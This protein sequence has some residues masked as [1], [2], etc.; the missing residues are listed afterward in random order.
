MSILTILL[1]FCFVLIN[2]L[3]PFYLLENIKRFFHFNTINSFMLLLCFIYFCFTCY[4]ILDIFSC[5]Y[6]QCLNIFA[7]LIRIY[8]HA[9]V[10]LDTARILKMLFPSI[11]LCAC[12][13]FINSLFLFYLF[14]FC[15]N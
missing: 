9:R 5:Q 13:A 11:L 14:V 3:F 15:F 2:Y 1:C 7:M 12:F 4:R 10:F 6:N 8:Y